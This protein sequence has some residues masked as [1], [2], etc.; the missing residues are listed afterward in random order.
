ML[1][2][3]FPLASFSLFPAWCRAVPALCCSPAFAVPLGQDPCAL[4]RNWDG[5]M[6]LQGLDL[7][8]LEQSLGTP[9]GREKAQ[10][11]QP[12]PSEPWTS[13]PRLLTP[14]SCPEFSSHPSP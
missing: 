2:K 3:H 8:G 9:K 13:A 10:G 1:V 6:W 5:R 4:G 7:W 14:H 12:G 11:V